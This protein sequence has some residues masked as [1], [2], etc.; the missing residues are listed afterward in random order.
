M[1]TWSE[2]LA[3]Y[4]REY[5]GRSQLAE[6][7]NLVTY[8]AD[9]TD[10]VANG[11]VIA[12]TSFQSVMAYNLKNGRLYEMDASDIAEM[13]DLLDLM[14]N[15]RF[16]CA[17]AEYLEKHRMTSASAQ[18]AAGTAQGAMGATPESA[19]ATPESAGAM[20]ES[21]GASAAAAPAAGAAR[22]AWPD[23]I[24]GKLA[25]LA[26]KG[27]SSDGESDSGIAAVDVQAFRHRMETDDEPFNLNEKL[28]I[29]VVME[30][31]IPEFLLTAMTTDVNGG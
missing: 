22:T 24:A 23:E 9:M 31:V 10:E 17:V 7:M 20:P 28:D 2:R 18:G 8:R 26:G 5:G 27:A 13:I 3:R 6:W 19:G 29:L 16:R 12:D 14:A 25:S 21:A 11:Q 30:A 4:E 15:V 1:E